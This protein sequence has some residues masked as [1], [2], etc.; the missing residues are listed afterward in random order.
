MEEF[1]LKNNIFKFI[2]NVKQQLAR[3]TVGTKL[4]PP[5]AYIYMD[6]VE[7]AFLKTKDLQP[8]WFQYIDLVF[9]YM[10]S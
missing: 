7:T 2:G 8:L 6:E 9:F 4:A 5:Y 10:E 3:S 1:V